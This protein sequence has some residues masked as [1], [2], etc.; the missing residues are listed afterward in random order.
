[1]GTADRTGAETVVTRRFPAD[2]AGTY[3]NAR[4]LC[5]TADA[6][7]EAGA[8]DVCLVILESAID[9][10][11]DTGTVGAGGDDIGLDGTQVEVS[12]LRYADQSGT[13]LAT[14]HGALDLQPADVP[15]PAVAAWPLPPLERMVVTVIAP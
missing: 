11:Y 6:S 8:P 13:V 2:F 14:A 9:I 12:P 7:R 10:A 1:M 3:E 15:R 5:G 4:R